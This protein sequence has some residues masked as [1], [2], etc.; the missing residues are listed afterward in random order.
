MTSWQ[1]PW[2]LLKL[3]T[4]SPVRQPQHSV[5]SR[6]SQPDPQLMYLPLGNQQ[7]QHHS[8]GSSHHS[9]RDLLPMRLSCPL[10][11]RPV[12]WQF[13][14]SSKAGKAC[15]P[16]RHPSPGPG[17]APLHR[18][19]RPWTQKTLRSGQSSPCAVVMVYR[20]PHQVV[21]VMHQ[22]V[23]PPRFWLLAR[24]VELHLLY[25]RATP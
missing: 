22:P 14:T 17:T 3:K 11:M 19:G 18:C 20:D 12:L 13:K 23:L 10:M 5:L 8:C 4:S 6:L 25:L 16:S 9:P 1:L 7:L 15:L 2:Q 21:P 24:A